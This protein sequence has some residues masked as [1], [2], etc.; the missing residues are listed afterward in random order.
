VN[1]KPESPYRDMIDKVMERI[2]DAMD[3]TVFRMDHDDDLD[4]DGILVSL[5]EA[6]VYA[7]KARIMSISADNIISINVPND[8]PRIYGDEVGIDYGNSLATAIDKAKALPKLKPQGHEKVRYKPGISKQFKGAKLFDCPT[9]G[10]EAG[11]NCFKFEGPGAHPK[12]T[13][14]RNDGSFFH[15]KRQDLAKAY[16]DRIRKAN[17]LH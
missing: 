2:T 15:S 4:L 17:I 3:A 1:K 6:H 16:N 9:C 11:T 5:A 14:E 12:L 7:N 13:N 10:A 8:Q